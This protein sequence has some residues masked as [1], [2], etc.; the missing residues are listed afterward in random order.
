MTEICVIRFG[1]TEMGYSRTNSFGEEGNEFY[2]E[3]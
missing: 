2:F 1:F 3:A